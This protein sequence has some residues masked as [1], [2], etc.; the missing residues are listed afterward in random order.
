MIVEE[1]LSGG[2]APPLVV[3]AQGFD[4]IL[5]AGPP[6]RIGRD[7]ECDVVVADTRVS[8]QHAVLRVEDSHWVL[9]DTGS[10]NGTFVGDRRVD[11]IEIDGECHARLGHPGD[12]PVLSC[13]VRDMSPAA[14]AGPVTRVT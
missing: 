7:P 14:P 13:T 11:R 4:R 8:W 10:T 9:A 2:Y 5:P 1:S 3:R 12:G 6:Y